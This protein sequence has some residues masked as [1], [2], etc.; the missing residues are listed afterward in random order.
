M[1]TFIDATMLILF[2]MFM[3]FIQRGYHHKKSME[4]EQQRKLDEE[5]AMKESKK[6]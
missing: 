4:R 1:G 3:I 6:P 5:K 2:V